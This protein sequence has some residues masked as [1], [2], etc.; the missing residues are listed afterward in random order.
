MDMMIITMRKEKIRDNQ[1]RRTSKKE[2]REATTIDR[3]EDSNKG[4]STN[5]GTN[6]REEEK[7]DRETKKEQE[8]RTLRG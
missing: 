6:N 4:R 7:I 5:L 3:N 1:E 2:I 8:Q